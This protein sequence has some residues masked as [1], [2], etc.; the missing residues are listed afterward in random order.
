MT[1]CQNEAQVKCQMDI[2]SQISLTEQAG[3]IRLTELL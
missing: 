1:L 2:D 3:K